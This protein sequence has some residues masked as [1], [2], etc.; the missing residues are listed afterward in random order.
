MSK[1]DEILDKWFESGAWKTICT[2]ANEL[3]DEDSIKLMEH[4]SD[5]LN[6]V[7]FHLKNDSGGERLYYELCY[8][9]E[10]CEEFNVDEE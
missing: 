4:I 2:N 7:I 10:L 8:F 6:S 3:N 5:Q 1:P 9:E